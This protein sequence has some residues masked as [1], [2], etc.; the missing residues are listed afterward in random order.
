MS[1]QSDFDWNEFS[2][3]W[4]IQKDSTYLNHG[5][6]GPSP[7]VVQEKRK[8]LLTKLEAQPMEF[9]IRTTPVLMAEATQTLAAFLNCDRDNIAFVPNATEAMN[10]VAK[11]VSLSAGDEVLITDH[12]YGSVLRIWKNKCQ[13]TGA[14][15]T[16][17]RLP[18]TLDT[19]EEVVEAIFAA[20]TNKT[21]VIV[22][23]HITSATAVI[24]PVK[25]IC[26]RAK[27]QK[28]IVV[29]D[30]PHAPLQVDVNLR[31]IDPD[32]YC[33]STH[34][35]LS[36]PMGTGFLYVRSRHKQ[37]LQPIALSW[38]RSLQGDTPSWTDEF[39]WP[40]TFD[41]TGYLSIPTAINFFK[42]IGLKRFREQTHALAKYA[43][44]RLLEFTERAPLSI[45]SDQWYGSMITVPFDPGLSPDL[46]PGEPHPL[47]KWLATE[48]GFEVPVFDWHGEWYLRVSCHLYNSPEQIDRLIE[49]LRAWGHE[50]SGA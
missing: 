6:F 15:T 23:S 18:K 29:I 10:I 35:W 25:E 50:N 48:H 12:E 27:K 26:D 20:V 2:H 36:A 16:L 13:Q 30:G 34:K 32:F 7:L 40:G 19:T 21:K 42:K 1:I 44:S 28:I 11:N 39:H 46:R 3:F 31:S 38:G 45:D 22:V 8:E 47:Q 4:K 41:P 5:S 43:R 49:L 9:L 33:A 24:L 17:A 37:G 14:V